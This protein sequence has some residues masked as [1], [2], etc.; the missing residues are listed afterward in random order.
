VVTQPHGQPQPTQQRPGV[1]MGRAALMKDAKDHMTHVI[2]PSLN[3]N[4]KGKFQ[5]RLIGTHNGVAEIELRIINDNKQVLKS[6][7]SKAI[8]IGKT[9]TLEGLDSTINFL[10][11]DIK[12]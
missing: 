3:P 8:S 9:I 11:S 7:G 1:N 4:V 2:A 12:S 5:V 10:P 6:F